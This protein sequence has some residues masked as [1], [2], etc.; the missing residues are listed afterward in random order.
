M[1]DEYALDVTVN[2]DK[3]H[4][5]LN[6]RVKISGDL[7]RL[8]MATPVLSVTLAI[9]QPGIGKVAGLPLLDFKQ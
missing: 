7:A 3:D 8:L 9:C 4:Y 2:T 5:P 1:S 6:I